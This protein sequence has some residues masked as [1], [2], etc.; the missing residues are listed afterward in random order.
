[1]H[2]EIG[3]APSSSVLKWID[4][5]ESVLSSD[6]PREGPDVPG[7]A[8]V[9]F[10]T[11]LTEWRTVAEAGPE[12]VWSADVPG[13]VAEYQVLAFYRIAERLAEAAAKRG[14][15][16]APPEAEAF[17][18]TLVDCLLEALASEGP[19]PSEFAEH[20]RSFWPGL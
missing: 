9:A 13:E 6:G 18:V 14:E 12:F 15:P 16:L 1:V 5:A 19:G 11:Y 2:V 7:D 10:A 17:Y 20:L 4:Y 3:P 8:V